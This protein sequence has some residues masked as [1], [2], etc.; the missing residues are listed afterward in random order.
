MVDAMIGCKGTPVRYKKDFQPIYNIVA[1]DCGLKFN[2]LR[3][4]YNLDCSVTVVPCTTSADE[5]L[6]MNPDGII[7]SPGPGDP[8]LL[9]YMIKT[10]KELLRKK[11]IMG[12]CLGHQL[13]AHAFGSRT[14]KLKF[15]HHGGNHPVRDLAT[16]RIYI[17][18]QNHGYAVDGNSVKNG[19]E[20]SQINSND[21]T[22]EGLRHKELPILSI[23]YHSEGAPGPQDNVYL[24][25]RFL[26]MIEEVKN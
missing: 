12:I 18:T 19:L 20:V 9:D 8:A 23:Q 6:K 14:F 7:L 17:T 22:V 26:E 4:L 21:G 15:G 16:G 5:I 3:I 1:I 11:P 13:I 10:V 2:I 25:N 24:F